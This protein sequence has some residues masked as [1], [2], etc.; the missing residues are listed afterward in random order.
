MDASIGLETRND[1]SSHY[2][3]P[4]VVPAP[5]HGSLQQKKIIP[6]HSD[7]EMDIGMGFTGAKLQK[8]RAF[9][10]SN[11]DFLTFKVTDIEDYKG[12]LVRIQSEDDHPTFKRPYKLSLSE[13]EG[14]K[15]RCKKLL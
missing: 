15:L 9:I 12:K 3:Q 7:W 11:R 6:G 14:V 8:V 2:W 5:S 13:K 1:A 10:R 4:E